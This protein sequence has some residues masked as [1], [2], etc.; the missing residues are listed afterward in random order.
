[1][2]MVMQNNFIEKSDQL[3]KE[4]EEWK[5]TWK[6]RKPCKEWEQNEKIHGNGFCKHYVN[7]RYRQFKGKIHSIFELPISE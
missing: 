6:H 2:K 5:K 7:A 1:M 3:W 4:T